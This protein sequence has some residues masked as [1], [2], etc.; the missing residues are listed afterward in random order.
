MKITN[1]LTLFIALTCSTLFAQEV[2]IA[3]YKNNARA[4]YTLIHDDFGAYWARGIEEYVDTM[5]FNRNIPICFAVI[6]KECGKA[7]WKKANEMIAHHHQIINHSMSHKCGTR[8][9]W[10]E[11]AGYWDEHNFNVEID[12]STAWIKRN[13]GKIPAFFIFPFDLFTDSMITYLKSKDYL[14]A[15][16]GKQNTTQQ[17]NQAIPFRLNFK[18]RRPED[19]I[20][21]LDSFVNNV[22]EEKSWGIQVLHGVE[23]DSWG[24]VSQ[25]EYAQY[26]NHLAKFSK[27]HKL[28]IATLSDVV[29]YQYMSAK[30]VPTVKEKDTTGN[31]TSFTFISNDQVILPKEEL[32]SD[33]TVSVLLKQK[34]T[35]AKKVQQGDKT[36]TFIIKEDMLIINAIPDQ[37]DIKITY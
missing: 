18:M 4:A 37:T 30:Y 25:A 17:A 13:T 6:T 21:E 28:W 35:A 33:K 19:P 2:T 24:K 10:C 5:C 20:A 15:R 31:V 29:T 7:D 14:G 11:T 12:S 34:N 32:L 8:E 3:P 26:L 22:V 36:L 27:E 1:T 9:S 23:D 16:A